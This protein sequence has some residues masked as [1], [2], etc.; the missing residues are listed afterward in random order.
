MVFRPAKPADK[1]KKG[2]GFEPRPWGFTGYL[3]TIRISL[4]LPQPELDERLVA[5][6]IE[7]SKVPLFIIHKEK[8]VYKNFTRILCKINSITDPCQATFSNLFQPG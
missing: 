5:A 3:Q 7:K 2:R 1:I 4:S 6:V 8:I